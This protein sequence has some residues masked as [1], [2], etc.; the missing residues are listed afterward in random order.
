MQVDPNENDSAPRCSDPDS[1]FAATRTARFFDVAGEDSR[2]FVKVH[3]LQTG[4]SQISAAAMQSEAT[5]TAVRWPKRVAC[6]QYLLQ[7]NEHSC[8]GCD[9][10]CGTRLTNAS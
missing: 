5:S 8:S 3:G 10:R 6:L 1:R 2:V 7:I 4:T 9:Q